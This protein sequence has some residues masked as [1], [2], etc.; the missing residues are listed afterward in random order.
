MS[1][2][3]NQ[4][5]V[6]SAKS[7]DLA[8]LSAVMET[9]VDAILT[10]DAN[11]IVETFNLAAEQ[12][13]GCRAADVLGQNVS[14]LMPS[15]HASHH[16]R[17]MKDYEGSGTRRVLGRTRELNARRFDG[18][19]FPI[20][21]ALSGTRIDGD[22]HFTGIIR[23]ITERRQAEAQL[24]EYRDH[25]EKL[26]D[27][28]TAALEAANQHLEQAS[29]EL[30]HA[31]TRL[32]QLVRVDE[33]TG[34]GNRRAFDEH[35]DLEW[36]R[37]TRAKEPVALL[38]C[39]VDYFKKYNDYYGHPAGD[40]CLRL[41]GDVLR[42]CF[43][44]ANEFP[45]RYGGEE[46]AVILSGTVFDDA[47]ERAEAL[48]DSVAQLAI[49]HHGVSK[50]HCVSVSVGLATTVP[51]SKIKHD[52]LLKAADAALYKAKQNGRNRVESTQI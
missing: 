45:A 34:I 13:F 43:Q 37:Q 8:R 33:L 15:H 32:E 11:G 16:D 14:T 21:L 28:R 31:N 7:A 51:G 20:E 24:Q 1:K 41:I 47:M 52:Q 26:V 40:D 27:E 22:M 9:A 35:M 2:S 50:N 49:P 44:R 19:E 39:D 3:I 48:R 38:L 6:D 36:R 23:D 12:M 18:T 29:M 17:Y 5:P 42:K 4:P 30:Q 46:F 10:T 25:L